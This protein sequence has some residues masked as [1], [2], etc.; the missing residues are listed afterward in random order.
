MKKELFDEFQCSAGECSFTCCNGWEILLDSQE[1]EKRTGEKD[2]IVECNEKCPFERK[3]GL[4]DIVIQCGEEALPE[5]CDVFPRLMNEYEE[6]EEYS[7]SFGCPHVFDMIKGKE[8]MFGCGDISEFFEKELYIRE[9]MIHIIKEEQ[10]LDVALLAAWLYLTDSTY[11]QIE[12]IAGVSCFRE[13]VIEELNNLFQDLL[14]NYMNVEKYKSELYDI[15]NCSFEYDRKT[16][17]EKWADFKQ[18][19]K[20]WDKLLRYCIAEK[21]YFSCANEEIR[22]MAEE[23]QIIITEYVMVRY[24]CFLK[25]VKEEMEEIPHGEVRR[26][27]TI[28]SRILGH[29]SDSVKEFFEILPGNRLWTVEY[30]VLITN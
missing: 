30:A 21:I 25:A 10:Q 19:F 20:K 3:D 26:Y 28:F 22:D 8:E 24:A 4:C 23:L 6:Y 27:M 14:I 7:L 1:C 17:E 18:N 13:E 15:W 12:Q 9:N 29:N 16:F 5:T 2:Y 11:E